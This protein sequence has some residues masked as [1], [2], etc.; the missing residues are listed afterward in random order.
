MK[1]N[2]KKT[3]LMFP[4]GMLGAAFIL[5]V[6]F[7]LLANRISLNSSGREVQPQVNQEEL[8]AIQNSDDL[9]KVDSELVNVD[10]NQFDKELNQL[11]IDASTF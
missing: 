5:L 2:Q 9:N 4:L 3:S 6:V 10:L 1:D 8:P 11:D 7:S